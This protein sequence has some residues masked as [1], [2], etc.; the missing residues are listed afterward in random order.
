[1]NQ[2]IITN[3]PLFILQCGLDLLIVL[4]VFF[5]FLRNIFE[6][7]ISNNDCLMIILLIHFQFNY[8]LWMIIKID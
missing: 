6:G 4:N 1:M 2:F 7:C 8:G 3:I 5:D